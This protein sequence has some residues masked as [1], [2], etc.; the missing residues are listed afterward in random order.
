MR[1]FKRKREE[2]F[3]T[4]RMNYGNYIRKQRETLT[5]HF[6]VTRCSY[7]IINIFNYAKVE[8]YK[9]EKVGGPWKRI[10][11]AILNNPITKPLALSGIRK[12]V[13]NGTNTKFWFDIWLGDSPLK[14]LFPRLFLLASISSLGFWEGYLWRWS[15]YWRRNLR[16]RDLSDLDSLDKMLQEVH[17]SHGSSDE[18]IWC[19]NDDGSFSVK[20][21]SFEMDKSSQTPHHIVPR[22]YGV[23]WSPRIE[24]FVWLACQGKINTRSKLEKM[25]VI[26]PAENIC[27]FVRN[28]EN[29]LITSSFIVCFHGKYG[30]GG[31]TYGV[32]HGSLLLPSM[33]L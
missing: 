25:K 27:L 5:F 18:L 10:C 17:I 7:L 8:L 19:L 11:A 26:T 21:L 2:H 32:S 20:S 14:N 3:G 4:P 22:I 12:K 33:K 9:V 16:I 15:F 31:V 23:A 28:M 13:G 24:I 6:F 1:K 30:V 29:Q